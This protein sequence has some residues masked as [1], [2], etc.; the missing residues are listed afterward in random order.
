M[1]C[2]ANPHTHVH[3]CAIACPPSL[4]PSAL[5]SSFSSLSRHFLRAYIELLRR[6]TF[7]VCVGF[8]HYAQC[9]QS[10]LWRQ[11]ARTSTRTAATGTAP[12]PFSFFFFFFFILRKLQIFI[13]ATISLIFIAYQPPPV[14]TFLAFADVDCTPKPTHSY[15]FG[16]TACLKFGILFISQ[17]AVVHGNVALLQN[18][19]KKD[20]DLFLQR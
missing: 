14:R 16:I 9:C 12:H 3:K 8:A 18:G 4:P 19:S 7:R 1:A 10:W 17:L 6:L 2:V 5:F 11:V 15:C 13:Y 20:L